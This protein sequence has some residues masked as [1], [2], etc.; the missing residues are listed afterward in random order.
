MASQALMEGD[1]TG[2]ET[3]DFLTDPRLVAASI[4]SDDGCERQ[5]MSGCRQETVAKLRG[6]QRRLPTFTCRSIEAEQG[7][8]GILAQDVLTTYPEAVKG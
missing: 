5:V 8:I 2:C 1:D 6:M 3:A 7:S 4:W